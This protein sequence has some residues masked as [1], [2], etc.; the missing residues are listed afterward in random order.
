MAADCS[1]QKKHEC[2]EMFTLNR[3]YK[4]D[5]Q[6]DTLLDF[7]R[8]QLGNPGSVGVKAIKI[9]FC[10]FCGQKLI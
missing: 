6:V 3:Y 4:G 9:L 7:W 8:L 5:I 1:E 10:P 2:A